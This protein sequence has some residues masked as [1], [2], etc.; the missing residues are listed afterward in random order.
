MFILSRYSMY[1]VKA[2][3]KSVSDY[4]KKV[5]TVLQEPRADP[6]TSL[7]CFIC[8]EQRH[9]H[10]GWIIDT[11]FVCHIDITFLMKQHIRALKWERGVKIAAEKHRVAKS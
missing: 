1:T 7:T 10:Q 4:I 5:N 8:G 9:L 2:L 11:E 6:P 3:R